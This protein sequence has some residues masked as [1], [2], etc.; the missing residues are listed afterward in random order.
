M[1]IALALAT[2]HNT[3][4]KEQ[5]IVRDDVLANTAGDL[6]QCPG[7]GDILGGS[8]VP[9]RAGWP[10]EFV[11]DWR[12]S[13]DAYLELLGP[14]YGRAIGLSLANN[15]SLRERL[16]GGECVT[17]RHVGD[18]LAALV[19]EDAGVMDDLGT[20]PEAAVCWRIGASGSFLAQTGEKLVHESGNELVRHCVAP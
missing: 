9:V 5:V 2:N 20:N 13:D 17:Q 1:R 8:R 12:A 4:A 16:R 6:A 15:I 10:L 14:S 7:V 18:S 11:S 3:H 19:F